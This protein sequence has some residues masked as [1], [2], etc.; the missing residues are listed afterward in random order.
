MALT[1]GL[2]QVSDVWNEEGDTLVYLHSRE[3]GRGPSFKIDSSLITS[4][5]KLTL[6][7]YGNTHRKVQRGPNEIQHRSHVERAQHLTVSH[8]VASPPSSPRGSSSNGSSKGSRSISDDFNEPP[9]KKDIHLCLPVPLQAD[10]SNPTAH[11]TVED[12][13]VL[14][15]MRNVFAFLAGQPLVSTPKQ[16]SLFRIF[17]KIA[18]VMQRY[19]FTNLN[20]STLGE[21]AAGRFASIVEDWQLADVRVSREKTI[22]AI[23]LGERMRSSSLY[24]EGFVHAVGKY[25]EISGLNSHKYGLIADVTRKRLERANLDLFARL[26]NIRTRLNDFEFPALFAGAAN[27][28]S[29]VESKVIRFKDWRSSYMSMRRHI[30]SLYK[31]SYGAWPP[32]AKSKKNDFEESGL[33]R[34]LLR[35]VYQD[36]SDLYDMLVD[37]TALTTRTVDGISTHTS[38]GR[39][40]PR[41]ISLR[42][43]ME[44]FDRSSP[45]VLP[46]MPFDIARLPSL[47]DTRRGFDTL[48]PK[49]QKKK[50]QKRLSEDEINHALMQSYNRENIKST[51]FIEAFMAFERRSARGK[52]IEEMQDLRDGQW[53]FIYAVLQS[54]PLVVVDAPGVKWTKGVEY[55]LCEVPKGSAPWVQE[56]PTMR[57]SWYGIAGGSGIISLP[58]DIVEHG[59][60]GIYHRSHC[61]QEA[62]KWGGF[63]EP[64]DEPYQDPPPASQLLSPTLTSL[65]GSRSASQSP[66]RRSRRASTTLGLEQL[67]LPPGVV[68]S[69]SRPVSTH[70]PLK[71]FGAILAQTEGT[72]KSKK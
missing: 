11:P 46:P 67:P 13:E 45:P 54:L 19:E 72:E 21:E 15:T 14:V 3:F 49:K 25:E 1:L 22:E 52:S 28:T 9:D 26:R 39:E 59:V 36:F 48:A 18:D 38:D 2:P 4:S 40:D 17:L 33:N 65:P 8:G 71:T 53:L 42:R 60:E 69:G 41:E 27:S 23:V 61:W 47:L 20:G 58:A 29:S 30:I 63:S 62:E 10:L 31:Q 37:R 68:P 6:A 16:S 70:D 7:A 56:N 5:R 51:P 35:D 44:D 64:A 66:N 34:L 12:V 32:K 50:N 57:Q 55:F 24:N 43:V